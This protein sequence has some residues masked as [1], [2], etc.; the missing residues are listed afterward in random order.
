M[1][2]NDFIAHINSTA[3]TPH[4]EHPLA[5]HLKETARLAIEYGPPEAAPWLQLAGLW[6]D[7]GKY[8]P[9]FQRYI[10]QNPD[11]HAKECVAPRS[12]THSTA[13]A[14][15]A[16]DRFGP[17]GQVLAYLIASHHA[18]LYDGQN[19]RSRLQDPDARRELDEALAAAPTEL[20][21]TNFAPELRQT[22]GSKSGFALWLRLLF[23]A[24]VDADF[25]DTERFMDEEKAR[26]RGAYPT[27]TELSKCF[28]DHMTAKQADISHT[29]DTPVNR[30]R[31]DVLRQCRIAAAKPPGLYSLTVPTG[32]GKTLSSLAFALDHARQH[33][34]RRII[35]AIP[36]TSII[37]QTAEV[38]TDIF[39]TENVLEHHSQAEADPSDETARL[40]LASENWDAPLIVT[41]N[42]QLFES[43]FAAKTSRCRKLHNLIDSVVILDEAQCLPPEYL[44]PILD[45]LNLL[46]RHYGVT[47]LLCTATQPALASRRYF[48]TARNRRGLDNVTEIIEQPDDLYRTLKRVDVRLPADWQTTTAWNALATELSQRDC[49]LAIV[50]TRADARALWEHLPP[51]TL[52]LSALMCGAHR[53]SVIEEIRQR[54]AARRSGLDTRPL[55]VVSTQLVEAG[56]DLDFPVVYRAFAGLDS[57]AQ[58]AGRCNREGRLE[59]GEVVVFNPPKA[60]PPGQL[61]QAADACLSVLQTHSGDPLALELFEPYFDRLYYGIDLDTKGIVRDLTPESNLD[62]RF[63]TA[64]ENFR[65]IDDEDQAAIF[66]RYANHPDIDMLLLRLEKEGPERW[67]MRK[68][69]RYAVNI[70]RRQLTPLLARGDVNE[71]RPGCY[72]QRSNLLY[73]AQLGLLAKDTKTPPD[74]L[75]L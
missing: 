56:V 64:A 60:P 17:A 50:N 44:Q 26:Q 8:R 54:L 71:V 48:D 9:G 66:V 14:L 65:L 19:L 25:L 57:L 2:L 58:A 1:T 62:I 12:K 69:Q 36:Y 31:A 61:R 41:T 16:L 63:R 59:R 6:H 13:G 24:L 38:F 15:L 27:L 74:K 42:V 32:G 29:P 18:G 11:A 53:A 45:V 43:L 5:E 68:L 47:V 3:S 67:L 73:D 35:Y 75:I 49:V 21:E 72:V 46:A 7:L 4:N 40:R 22:P 37:E 23:S 52:H 55:R 28:D 33:G 20:I 10:R 39:G 51:G 70:P 34:K 30:L